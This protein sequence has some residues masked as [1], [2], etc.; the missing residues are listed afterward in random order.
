MDMR[1]KEMFFCERKLFRKIKSNPLY[2]RT[3]DTGSDDG[4]AGLY[5]IKDTFGVDGIFVSGATYRTNPIQ[6]FIKPTLNNGDSEKLREL[7][8][9][10]LENLRD[11]TDSEFIRPTNT[12]IT[13]IIRKYFGLSQA[14]KL[15][16]ANRSL[17]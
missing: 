13:N 8:N 3:V 7:F 6:I 10:T 5:N 9:Q 17:S 4:R 11:K 15:L 1:K 2:I 12:A 16:Q 14:K